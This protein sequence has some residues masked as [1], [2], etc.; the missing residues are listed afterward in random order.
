MNRNVEYFHKKLLLFSINA[1]EKNVWQFAINNNNCQLAGCA[2]EPP[3]VTSQYVSL[4]ISKALFQQF[5]QRESLSRYSFDLRLR[6]P[7]CTRKWLNHRI[8]NSLAIVSPLSANPPCC[9]SFA[10]NDSAVLREQQDNR[11]KSYRNCKWRTVTAAVSQRIIDCL[12][13][14]LVNYGERIFERK[15]ILRYENAWAH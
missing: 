6:A 10:F 15:I 1:L 9:S 12:I 11:T 7:E 5:L 2:V 14:F 13:S 4:H 3:I 8:S